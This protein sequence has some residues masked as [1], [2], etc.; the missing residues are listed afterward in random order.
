M[1]NLRG[2]YDEI[3]KEI[4]RIAGLPDFK[5]TSALDGVLEVAFQQTQALVHVQT[6]SL[7]ASGK[8]RSKTSG[9][10]WEGELEYGGLSTGV[11]NP[12]DYAM[13]E[14]RRDGGHDFMSNVHLLDAMWTDAI[15]TGLKG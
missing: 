15:L 4:D 10:K 6:G 2:D 8:K 13:Y 3:D 14:Q 9:D 5:T 1:I 11:N 12:V 7:K